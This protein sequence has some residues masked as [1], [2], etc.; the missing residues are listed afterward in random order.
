MSTP[1]A[2]RA[3][4]RQRRPPSGPSRTRSRSRSSTPAN[5]PR[6]MAERVA[7][8]LA[9]EL[10]AYD[11]VA[12]RAAGAGAAQDHRRHDHARCRR[13]APA[14]RS[15]STGT[16]SAAAASGPGVSKTVA[17]ANDYAEASDGLVSRIA[18][19]AAPRVATLMGKPP[20]FEARVAGPGRRRRHHAAGRSRCRPVQTRPPRRPRSRRDARAARQAPPPRTAPG[21]GDGG[22]DQRRAVG[23]Q[24]AAVLRH[25]PRAGLEQDRGDRQGR[26]R[27]LHRDGRG[28]AGAD[29]RPLRRSSRSSGR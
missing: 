1:Q 20:G 7:A 2:V 24:P 21:Q 23:R 26:Q 27:H 25:A 6:Q 12:A 4:C 5:M 15:R 9:I 17:Q 14:S 11:I 10:Q 13:S 16:C 19:Q 8:A 28:E 22:A 18:Q 29:R 3:R